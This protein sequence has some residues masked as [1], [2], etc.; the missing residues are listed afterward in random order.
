MGA[1]C[2]YGPPGYRDMAVAGLDAADAE[3]KSLAA[4]MLE[5]GAEAVSEPRKVVGCG[6]DGSPVWVQLSMRATFDGWR[7]VYYLVREYN[8]EPCDKVWTLEMKCDGGR[9]R[10]KRC[11]SEWLSKN[12]AQNKGTWRHFRPQLVII[13]SRFLWFDATV[14]SLMWADQP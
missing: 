7:D 14:R 1:L 13:S 5:A 8:D 6:R 4:A 3:L 11:V 2:I 12:I 10:G 9:E